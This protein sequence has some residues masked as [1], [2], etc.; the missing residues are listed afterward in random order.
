MFFHAQSP[1]SQA[2][3]R[4]FRASMIAAAVLA[5]A[6]PVD[7][8]NFTIDR[9]R[10]ELSKG[11]TSEVI[12]ILNRSTEPLRLQ[13]T[14]FHWSQAAGEPMVL[15]PTDEIV[16]FPTVLQ[17]EPGASRQVRVGYLGTPTSRERTYRIILEE[18]PPAPT[19]ADNLVRVLTRLNVPVFVEAARPAPSPRLGAVAREGA[20][21]I[22]PVHNGGSSHVMIEAVAISAVDAQGRRLF[23]E[24]VS[25]WYVLA[26][27]AN[28]FNVALPAEC[29]AAATFHIS[30]RTAAQTLTT[31][32]ERGDRPCK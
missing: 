5:G 11:H 18:L 4:A 24:E 1:G 29:G 26:E 30:V 9:T 6:S 3:T 8:S 12:T 28:V 16:Y 14:G 15:E 25:G 2:W 21:V 17:L 22:V 10:V 19:G 20:T 13:V 32:L 27:S 23:S 7:A 31:I